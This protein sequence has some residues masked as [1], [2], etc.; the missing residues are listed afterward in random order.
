MSDAKGTNTWP[1]LAIGLYDSL[2][3]AR[4]CLSSS[5]LPSLEAF[6]SVPADAIRP[7]AGVV[8]RFHALHTTLSLF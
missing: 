1:E 8:E 4:L 2:T 5:V 6:T 3:V 7:C